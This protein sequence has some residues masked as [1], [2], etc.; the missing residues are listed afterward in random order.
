MEK[1]GWFPKSQIFCYKGGLGVFP[2][3]DFFRFQLALGN[4]MRQQMDRAAM[5]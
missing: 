3:M 2:A 4:I 5:V 1:I